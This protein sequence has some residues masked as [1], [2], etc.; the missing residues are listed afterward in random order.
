M[1]QQQGTGN[2]LP[3]DE[4]TTAQL[5]SS[6]AATATGIDKTWTPTSHRK[7]IVFRQFSPIREN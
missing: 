5:L 3:E 2:P 6:R 1:R 7:V 4:H